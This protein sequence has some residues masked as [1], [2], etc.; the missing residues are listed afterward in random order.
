MDRAYIEVEKGGFRAQLGEAGNPFAATIPSMDKDMPVV[1]GNVNYTIAGPKQKL[2]LQASY[3]HGR[4]I[5]DDT[6]TRTLAAQALHTITLLDGAVI[7]S[8]N[9]GYRH[10]LRFDDSHRRSNSQGADFDVL[11][12]GA[13]LAFPNFAFGPK[14]L[15]EYA[16]N[17]AAD[18]GSDAIMAG[19]K[20]G[21]A[22]KPGSMAFTAGFRYIG[23]DSMDAGTL[24]RDSP[25]SNYQN[26]VFRAERRLS[27]N[28][29][30]YLFL[31]FPE[32]II[33]TPQDRDGDA[34]QRKIDL[35]VEYRF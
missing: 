33:R 25:G 29:S 32:H 23:K 2:E 11:S 20:L 10:V 6:K 26:W 21:E 5:T 13:S 28:V 12:A 7:A 17:F 24:D 3:D 16:H 19:V 8:G 34:R 31:G 9:L 15:F 4:I 18:T 27:E 14:I 22:D 35:G 30:L 1:G